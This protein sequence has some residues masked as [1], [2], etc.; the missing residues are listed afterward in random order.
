MF[1]SIV[2]VLHNLCR[3][4][5]RVID[6]SICLEAFWAGR[7]DAVKKNTKCIYLF[8]TSGVN[9]VMCTSRGGWRR[10]AK[11]AVC[12]T[13]ICDNFLGRGKRPFVGN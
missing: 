4:C 13:R 10:I 1:K 9:A 11:L 7:H 8:A 12:V 3:H 6:F 2:K 5:S